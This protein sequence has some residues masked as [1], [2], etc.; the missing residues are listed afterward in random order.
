[1]NYRAILLSAAAFAVALAPSRGRAATFELGAAMVADFN[2][3]DAVAELTYKD[4]S[5]Q[6]ITAGNGVTLAAGIGTIFFEEQDHRLELQLTAGAKLSTMR[7]TSNADLSWVRVPIELLA[8]Y[9]NDSLHF[10]IGGGASLCALN[11]LSGSGAASTIDA[12]FEPALGGVVQADFIWGNFY[13]GLRTTLVSYRP[14]GAT[15]SIS[16]NSIGIS[17]GPTLTALGVEKRAISQWDQ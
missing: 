2:L 12:K 13:A 17:L 16:A 10:R 3:G 11:S 4:G 15:R 8:F 7:P 1:M 14:E 5:T 6:E 9:R